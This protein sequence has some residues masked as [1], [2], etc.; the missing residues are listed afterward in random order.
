MTRT[1]VPLHVE[2]V[3]RFARALRGDLNL[4]ANHQTLLNA[5]ARAAG[6]ANFQ[7]LKARAT[8][9]EAERPLDLNALRRAAARFDA[10]GRFTGWSAKRSLR[11]LCLWPI[12][13]RLPVGVEMDERDVSARI[14]DLCTFRDAAGIRREMVGEEMLTRR[15]DGTGY[16]RVERRPDPTQR[17]LIRD[18]TG[19]ARRLLL[20][21]R[22]EA[23]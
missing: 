6:F 16:R 15:R 14:H 8:G 11:L 9:P 7:H 21:T 4:D 18:V 20:E 12:W 5:I 1:I 2:D 13:A 17:A 19:R 23:G 3:S 22:V 10:A